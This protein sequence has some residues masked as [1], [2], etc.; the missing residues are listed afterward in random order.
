MVLSEREIR[1]RVLRKL[2]LIRSETPK[3]PYIARYCRS[4]LYLTSGRSAQ[5]DSSDRDENGLSRE[6]VVEKKKDLS[7]QLEKDI[8]TSNLTSLQICGEKL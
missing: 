3:A 6:V 5:S 2:Q 4:K 8:Y 1:L 7:S